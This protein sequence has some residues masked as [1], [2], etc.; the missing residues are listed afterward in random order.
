MT[1]DIRMLGISITR[2]Y[3]ECLFLFAFMLSAVMLYV[4]MLNDMTPPGQASWATM[5]S[6]GGKLTGTGCH[7]T[8]KVNKVE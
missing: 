6:T 7:P 2:H 5:A 8:N 3:A 4:V 1:L